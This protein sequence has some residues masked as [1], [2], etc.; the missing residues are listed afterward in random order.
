MNLKALETFVTIHDSESFIDAARRLGFT[1]SAVS[2]QIKSLEEE[3]GAELFDRRVRPP[4]MTPAAIA[5]VTPAR[6]VLTLIQSIYD[7]VKHSQ[8]LSGRLALGV[9]PTATLSLLPDCLSLVSRRYPKIQVTVETGLS[10]LLLERVRASILDAAVITQPSEVPPDLHCEVLMRDRLVLISAVDSPGSV[11]L[12]TLQNYPFIRF[13]RHIGAGRIIDRF[14]AN[15]GLHPDEYM[16]L[17]SVAGI[18]AM[19]E[20]GLGVAIVPEY[21]VSEAYRQ[22]IAVSPIDDAEAVRYVSLIFR[23]H[24]TNLSLL[25]VV[26]ASFQSAVKGIR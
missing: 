13:V 6:E 7:R 21:A 16:E 8:T 9:V 1:Q 19:V 5:I 18:L 10:A 3:L 4:V 15:K 26:L 23:N 20:R 14:L 24:A 22:R 11:S 17:D 12:A 2:M 25:E